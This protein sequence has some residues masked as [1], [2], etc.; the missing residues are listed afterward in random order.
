MKYAICWYICCMGMTASRRTERSSLHSG[1]TA[2]PTQDSRR[3]LDGKGRVYSS[4]GEVLREQ[5]RHSGLTQ[6]QLSNLTGVSQGRISAYVNGREN[7]TDV[8][9]DRLLSPLGVAVQHS[10]MVTPVQHTRA[11]RLSWRFH[12]RLSELLTIDTFRKWE[13]K[14]LSNIDKQRR[15]NRGP[16]NQRRIDQWEQLIQDGDLQG[17]RRWL[18]E[19]GP[20]GIRMR[21]VSPFIGLL[22]Q[23]D[24]ARILTEERW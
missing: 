7:L 4:R 9:L 15:N 10:W 19:P 22:P 2:G 20:E 14:M 21:E 5:L 13:Q 16:E 18:T 8:M 6:Q 24:R 23:E 1:A 17:V 12:L 3:V 11:E